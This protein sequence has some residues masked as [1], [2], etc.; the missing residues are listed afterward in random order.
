MSKSTNSY[1]NTLEWH[2]RFTNATAID[3]ES[4]RLISITKPASV[5]RIWFS[6]ANN[7]D[8]FVN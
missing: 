8:T 3:L 5:T 2:N 4:N 6:K 1:A 7:I